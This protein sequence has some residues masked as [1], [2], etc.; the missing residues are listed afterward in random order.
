M[1]RGIDCWLGGF[2]RRTRVMMLSHL[3]SRVVW[4]TP[5]SITPP[6]WTEMWSILVAGNLCFRFLNELCISNSSCVLQSWAVFPNTLIYRTCPCWLLRSA[7]TPSHWHNQSLSTCFDF[8]WSFY[9]IYYIKLDD[10]NNLHYKM[11]KLKFQPLI[12]YKCRA[13]STHVSLE[14]RRLKMD[15]VS[16][17]PLTKISQIWILLSAQ[18]HT[19]QHV[20]W[21][22][23][24]VHVPS[25][26]M[27]EVGFMIYTAH[28]GSNYR[29]LSCRPSF[30]TVYERALSFV[31]S[32]AIVTTSLH[33][34]SH[35]QWLSHS[36]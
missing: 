23:S 36:K 32:D 31:H 6:W 1:L 28:L 35:L 16:P 22:F 2:P 5:L 9:S 21:L 34:E 11:L 30:C 7:Q 33:S 17:L 8:N 12:C 29:A 27:E 14:H 20:L 25:T 19:N 10:V 4:H 13:R 3:L 18:G 15:N 24:L 26:L